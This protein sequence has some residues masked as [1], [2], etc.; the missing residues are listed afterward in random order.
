LHP[1][2]ASSTL[3]LM[4]CGDKTFPKKINDTQ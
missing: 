3:A 1:L 4:T 2:I